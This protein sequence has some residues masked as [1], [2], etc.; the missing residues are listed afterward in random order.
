MSISPVIQKRLETQG[1]MGCSYDPAFAQVVPWLRFTPAL[2]MTLV[3]LG[4]ALAWPTLLLLLVPIATLGAIL[5]VH[6]ADLLY[7]YGLRYLTGTPPLPANPKPRRF[8]FGVAAIWLVMIA[9]AFL[10][11]A[12]TIGYVLGAILTLIPAI[13]VTVS[14]FCLWAQVYQFFCHHFCS[15]E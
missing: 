5:P 13:N 3:G 11:G 12:T 9:G 2:G 7:N 10:A 15:L 14:H 1:F 4:T 8:S 6:P